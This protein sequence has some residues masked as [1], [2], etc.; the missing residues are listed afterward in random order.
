MTV[1]LLLGWYRFNIDIVPVWEY[2]TSKT[3]APL[4]QLCSIPRLVVHNVCTNTHTSIGYKGQLFDPLKQRSLKNKEITRR[5]VGPLQA[6]SS[7]SRSGATDH[8]SG[9]V[10][11]PP[12][13]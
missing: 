9:S 8:L 5:S 13:W 2:S 4:H 11:G 10:A 6:D 7:G 3:I 1:L 12:W